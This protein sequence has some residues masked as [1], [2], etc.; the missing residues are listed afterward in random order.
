[1]AE[2]MHRVES[3]IISLVRIANED[4]AARWLIGALQVAGWSQGSSDQQ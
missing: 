3:G 1:M 2:S 4:N